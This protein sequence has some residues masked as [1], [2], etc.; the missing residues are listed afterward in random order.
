MDMYH[1]PHGAIVRRTR[2]FRIFNIVV[3]VVIVVFALFFIFQPLLPLLGADKVTIG[4]AEVK[5]TDASVFFADIDSTLDY[6]VIPTLGI[7]QEIIE[8]DTIKTVH[9]KVW[10][11]PQGSTPEEGS[12]TVLVAHRYATI[13]GNRSSTFY[14]LPDIAIGDRAY[15]RWNGKIYTYEV[16]G[17]QIVLPTAIEVEAPSLS[18]MLTLYTC[19]PL[20]KADKRFVATAT[21]ISVQ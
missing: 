15:V 20:W 14:L 8:A 13:G 3:E 2:L 16:G 6:L 19:T 18:P 21:L 1:D 9:E 10:I 11:R 5:K 12:N 7:S 4:T 17:T